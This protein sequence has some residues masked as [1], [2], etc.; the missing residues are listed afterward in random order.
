MKKFNQKFRHIKQRTIEFYPDLSHLK[1]RFSTEN[2]PKTS[3]G[4]KNYHIFKK[5]FIKVV[6]KLTNFNTKNY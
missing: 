6:N 3:D 2:R 5:L 4:N 1:G